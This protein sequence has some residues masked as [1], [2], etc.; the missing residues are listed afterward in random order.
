M[1]YVANRLKG[2]RSPTMS[3]E[4][5]FQKIAQKAA[6]NL[7]EAEAE[8]KTLLKQ[9]D[10]RAVLATYSLSRLIGMQTKDEKHSRP[11]P[12]ACELAAWV[13]YPEFGQSN[14]RDGA[15]IHA[16]IIALEK[17]ERA[18]TLV[19]IFP[20]LPDEEREDNLTMHL[21]VHSGIVRGSAFATQLIHRI[22]SILQPFEEELA[23]LAGIGPKQASELIREIAFQLESNVNAMR[24]NYRLA[25]SNATELAKKGHRL[26]DE[27]KETLK[28]YHQ[29]ITKILSYSEGEWIPKLSQ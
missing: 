17:H 28:G 8:V 1:L 23:T 29:R 14:V 10:A 11:A 16:A 5:E 22:E 9:V 3:A 19:E 21:R 6:E 20:Q 7:K 2:K 26:T 4:F 13:C 24:E 25:L 15:K 12:V 18:Y 27:D